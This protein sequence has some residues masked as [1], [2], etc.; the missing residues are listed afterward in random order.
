MIKQ[1]SNWLNCSASKDTRTHAR[2][3][4]YRP[5]SGLILFQQRVTPDTLQF[6]NFESDRGSL[7]SPVNSCFNSLNGAQQ[8][9]HQLAF[10]PCP[11]ICFFSFSP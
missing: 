8:A 5:E 9:G 2:L 10:H 4:Q 7:V 3:L 6:Q 11:L 1:D